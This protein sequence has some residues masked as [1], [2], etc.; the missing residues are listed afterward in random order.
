M[1]KKPYAVV[2]DNDCGYG[3]DYFATKDEQ[4]GFIGK[5]RKNGTTAVPVDAAELSRQSTIA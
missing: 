4:T 3:T 1:D 5:C 2:W